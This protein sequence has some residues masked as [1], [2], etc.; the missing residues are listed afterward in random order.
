MF[1]LLT[2]PHRRISDVKACNRGCVVAVD[3]NYW[4]SS[5]LDV[6]EQLNNKNTAIICYKDHTGKVR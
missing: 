6:L 3:H 5:P 4:I 2:S 1:G